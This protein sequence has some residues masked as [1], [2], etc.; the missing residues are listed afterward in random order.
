MFPCLKRREK[1]IDPPAQAQ[2]LR[3]YKLV[4]VG[5]GGQYF[6]SNIK[7]NICSRSI[8]LRCWEVRSYHPVYPK[9][10]R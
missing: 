4:V 1:L 6:I 7:R 8:T 9:S 5:G 3:E 2:F 10:L